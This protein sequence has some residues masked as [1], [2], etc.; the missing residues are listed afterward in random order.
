VYQT[1]IVIPIAIAL[2]TELT[3]KFRRSVRLRDAQC[4]SV[5]NALCLWK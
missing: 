3:R 4:P 1:K 5:R 2:L